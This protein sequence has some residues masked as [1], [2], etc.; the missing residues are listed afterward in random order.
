[1]KEW[2]RINGNS[3]NNRQLGE[4]Q[5]KLVLKWNWGNPEESHLATD[6]HDVKKTTCRDFLSL[7]NESHYAPL[8]LFPYTLPHSWQQQTKRVG[9]SGLRRG[10]TAFDLGP[11]RRRESGGKSGQEEEGKVTEKYFTDTFFLASS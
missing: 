11:L 1:M 7:C 3:I 9:F 4:K 5:E 2:I 10:R 6:G 8:L